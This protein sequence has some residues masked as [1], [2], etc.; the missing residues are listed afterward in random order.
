MFD[1]YK[2]K[3][4]LAYQKKIN[5][6]PISINLSHPSPAKLRTE[7]LIVYSER[8]LQKDEEILRSFFGPKDNIKGYH[9]NI[10]RF[11]IKGFKPLINFMMERTTDPDKR[12]V[13]LLAWLIDF[14][15]RPYDSRKNYKQDLE[16]ESALG[17]FDSSS[18]KEESIISPI[19]PNHEIDDIEIDLD[20]GDE[21]RLNP[22]TANGEIKDSE[23]NI[24]DNG[25]TEKNKVI[26]YEPQSG[27]GRNDRWK[28]I[29]LKLKIRKVIVS[30]LTIIVAGGISYYVVE[31]KQCMYWT[32][33]QYQCIACNKKLGDTAVIALDTIKVAHLR[34]IIRP[35]TLTESSL[36]KI[37]YSK[38][39]GKVE[40]FTSD[41]FHP[42]YTDRR[43]RPVTMYMLNK[44][45]IQNKQP[46]AIH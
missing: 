37:W 20:K 31:R 21:E 44:Y 13:E 26:I 41:G 36:G 15:P 30:F 25:D 46:L 38:I 43:L 17:G 24:S 35:D 8:P 34:K 32:G 11:Q 10:D 33:N 4:F 9:Q 40:F 2:K 5:V 42:L 23:T 18:E 22:N 19:T 1:D 45:V 16:K 6:G 3:V 39:D 29:L 27:T 14:E 28:A 12:I 7:C